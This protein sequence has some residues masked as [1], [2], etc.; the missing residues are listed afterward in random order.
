MVNEIHRRVDEGLL[1]KTELRKLKSKFIA[2]IKK[3]DDWDEELAA[4]D[5]LKS[6]V[7]VHELKR[8]VYAGESFDERLFRELLRELG[9]FSHAPAI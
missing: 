4:V 7:I 9:I 1:S 2:D 5:S 6:S 8:V 3:P